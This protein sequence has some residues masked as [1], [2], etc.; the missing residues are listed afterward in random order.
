MLAMQGMEIM[1]DKSLKDITERVKGA[2]VSAA[3]SNYFGN[4]FGPDSLKAAG[5][6]LSTAKSIATT[7]KMVQ[8]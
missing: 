4:T 5:P 6:F 2:D 1:K 7:A 3:Y 8:G